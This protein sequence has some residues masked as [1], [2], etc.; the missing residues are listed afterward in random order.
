MLFLQILPTSKNH[1]VILEF[2]GLKYKHLCLVTRI[3][4]KRKS[5]FSDS[6]VVPSPSITNHLQASLTVSDRSVA[7][8]NYL[9]RIK[10]DEDWLGRLGIVWNDTVTVTGG[11]R[12][13]KITYN[14]LDHSILINL[15]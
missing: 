2:L 15:Y 14:R 9:N 5:D 10:N 1:V 6:C 4:L 3:N 7:L 13:E 8:K 11:A 12:I